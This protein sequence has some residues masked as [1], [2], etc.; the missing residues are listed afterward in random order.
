VGGE[1]HSDLWG[2]AS[3]FTINRK[4]YFISFTDDHSRHT[5]IHLLRKK[6][7]VFENYLEYEAYLKTQHNV[8]IKKLHMDRGGEY[9]SIEF[10]DHLK[11]QGTI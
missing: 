10:S 1:I 9:M 6:D 8:V 4:E 3:V 11:K 7:Q 5:M 2:P